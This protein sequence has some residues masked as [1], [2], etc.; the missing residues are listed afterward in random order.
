MFESEVCKVEVE[1]LLLL[2]I[3]PPSLEIAVSSS[4]V[5]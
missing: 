4:L 1:K 5:K 2:F 3:C